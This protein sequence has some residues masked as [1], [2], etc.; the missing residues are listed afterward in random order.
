MSLELACLA[1]SSRGLGCQLFAP[2][3]KEATGVHVPC[4][5]FAPRFSD[6]RA[7]CYGLRFLAHTNL[8]K[9]EKFRGSLLFFQENV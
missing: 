1:P 4:W 2:F 6:S 8:G 7:L 9:L 3:H 5:V